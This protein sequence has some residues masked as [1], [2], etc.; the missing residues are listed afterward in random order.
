MRTN[1]LV[2]SFFLLASLACRQAAPPPAFTL[3]DSNQ[4]GIR[5]RNDLRPTADLNMLKYMYFYNGAGV[6]AADFNNDG[7]IDIFLA[8]NQV[9]DRLYLNEGN[10]HFR[11][12]SRQSGLPD[13]HGW[14]T[15]VSVIDINNDGLLDIY[16]CRVGNYESLQSHNLLLV[17]KGI[18][19]DSVPMYADEAKAY[20]LAFSGFSTQAAFLDYDMDGDLDMYLMNHSLRY[21]STFNER[22]YYRQ[23]YDSLSGD[24]LYR[25]DGGK[26]TNVTDKA[27]IQGSVI[28]YGLG[29]CVADINLDGYPD[30]Y[31]ANDFHENDY[32][33]INQRDGSF[34][35]EATE[36]MMHTSQFSMGVDISDINGD[37]RP[38]I[39][40]LDMLPEDP[41]IL[42]RS[43]GE[44]EYNLFQ[45]KL[46]YG[47]QHQYTRNNLQLNR[48][49]GS[50]SEI[51]LYAGI[52]A[53]DWSWSALWLD[54]N[55]D[56]K[57]DLFISNGIPKRLNDI[58]Y[59]NFIS[60]DQM[61]QKIRENKLSG[62]DFSV[63][64]QFP[65]IRLRNKFFIQGEELRF[66]DWRER[67]AGDRETF[68]NGAAYADFD[69]DGDLDIV[70]NNIDDPAMMYRNEVNNARS[71]QLSPE[72]PASNRRALGAR[73]I[74][75]SAGR[76]QTYEHYPV[77][78]FQSSME[79]PLHVG[80]RD[81][82]P[83]SILFVWPDGGYQHLRWE[84]QARVQRLQYQPG[85]PRFD[86]SRLAAPARVPAF[87]DITASTD[88][89][90]RH[91]ENPYVDFNREPLVPFMLSREGPA[92]AVADIN[93]DGKDDVFAGGAR[94]QPGRVFLQEDG[95]RFRP[96]VLPLLD[97]D[98]VYEDVDACWADMNRDGFV[99]L[100]VSSGGNEF[101]NR[102]DRMRARLYLNDG[103][104]GF[105]R[106]ILLPAAEHTLSRLLVDDFD[107]DGNPDLLAAGRAVPF[108]YGDIPRTNIWLG[109]GKGG[110]RDAPAALMPEMTDIGLV[111]A[112]SLADMD[113]DGDRDILV[114]CEW[115]GIFLFR[116]ERGRYVKRRIV[117]ESGWWSTV[118][119]ADINGDGLH[120]L[121]A[122][123]LGQNSR[124]KASR[125]MPVRLY[126]TDVDQ[127]GTVDQVLTY[128]L[129]GQEIPF[130]GKAELEKQIPS[131]R[132][133]FLYAADFARSSV[134]DVF[135]KDMINNARVLSADA[136]GHAVYLQQRDGSFQR[137]LLPA[138]AQYS[139]IRDM[140]TL[141][142]DGMQ[143]WLIAGNVDGFNIQMGRQDA[144][145]MNLLLRRDSSWEAY[146]LPGLPIRNEVRRIL[147]LRVGNRL[148]WVL[149]CNNDSL[150]I[151]STR[152]GKP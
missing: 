12:V 21:N 70:V 32:L 39:V 69:N 80:L 67:I 133:K 62:N 100:L 95:G 137:T 128:Y 103:G 102:D 6:G 149:A 8:G 16:V 108:R 13:D 40:T 122:G 27:G 82:D 54:L 60:G 42:R 148:S 34:R 85:L 44:D 15:G 64:E 131:L 142:M 106:R 97:A 58:D 5:F 139:P 96:L 144:G 47:Y 150:R 84:Q 45:M 26:Y 114:A 135:G 88:I 79:I 118:H 2:I 33:Y 14:S 7:R 89:R 87:E 115:S 107:G 57:R 73:V 134:R 78:G 53:T 99:D 77:R 140:A 110:F 28:G 94:D 48:A 86:M 31:V 113:G 75:Y 41:Y 121:I 18:G 145:G 56:G 130:A 68:S 105:S 49:D 129:D 59:V 22:P 74:V 50:F 93:G 23:Q 61:Q 138:E 143:G 127:N 112:L 151:I 125:E 4:T 104:R 63:I 101:Y 116:N 152:A 90:F 25:N 1:L 132:K 19:K 52:A 66:N 123:N 147:P 146:P 91:R 81:R 92:L 111:T 120:D 46:R 17:C 36:R 119:A 29:V 10:M 43:L 83:D 109:D 141:D 35:D 117:Q 72:G 98:S 51:G 136:F 3:L 11:D 30:I 71:L 76:M 20:G 38:E 37:A 124:L 65:Q 126:V 9:P 24:R 55:H